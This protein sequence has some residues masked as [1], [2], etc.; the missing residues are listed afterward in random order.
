MLEPAG[1]GLLLG[2]EGGLSLYSWPSLSRACTLR[3][4]LLQGGAADDDSERER[5]FKRAGGRGARGGGKRSWPRETYSR[6]RQTHRVLITIER[7]FKGKN[8]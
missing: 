4:S 3:L 1:L 8:R 2:G 6:L 5:S 7:L